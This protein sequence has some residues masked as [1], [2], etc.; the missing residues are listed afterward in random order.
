M[1]EKIISAKEFINS[2]DDSEV[3]RYYLRA[4]SE[5]RDNEDDLTILKTIENG[6]FY[7]T[8]K[9][10]ELGVEFFMPS[11]KNV[12]ES[13]ATTTTLNLTWN[14]STAGLDMIKTISIQR[15]DILLNATFRDLARE[16]GEA[17]Y[18]EFKKFL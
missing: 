14:C 4:V 16:M 7:L 1:Y 12:V 8:M 6:E 5:R 17:M 9:H 11:T 13:F 15:R 3:L 18:E 2:I 10:G